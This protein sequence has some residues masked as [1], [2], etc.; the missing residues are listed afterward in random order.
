L[1]SAARSVK[2][3]TTKNETTVSNKSRVHA[4]GGPIRLSDYNLFAEKSVK[5]KLD[6]RLQTARQKERAK[7]VLLLCL[8]HS[9]PLLSQT[10]NYLEHI[11]L[12]VRT[13]SYISLPPQVIENKI[14]ST[15]RA[16]SAN[17]RTA[18]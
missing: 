17:A 13:F 8:D 14:K 4:V 15:E 2:N 6:I 9:W 18:V 7:F 3:K 10:P 1:R 12:W 16:R 5:I 11:E